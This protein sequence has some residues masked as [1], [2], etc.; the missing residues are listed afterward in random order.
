MRSYYDIIDDIKNGLTV[1]KKEA[2]YVAQAADAMLYF[3]LKNI[4]DIAGS[5]D[6]NANI[7]TMRIKMAERYANE[8]IIKSKKLSVDKYLGSNAV[9]ELEDGSEKA[10]M[11]KE[12][13]KAISDAIDSGDMIKVI[14]LWANGPIQ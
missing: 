4:R 12:R 11:A 2:T 10:V 1:S 3:A 8:D 13:Q 14:G 6:K 7:L 9:D 5:I